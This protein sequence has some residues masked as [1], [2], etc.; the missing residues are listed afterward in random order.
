MKREDAVLGQ[1]TKGGSKPGYLDD[2]SV[3]DKKSKTETFASTVLYIDTPRW[4]G[5][6]IILKSGKGG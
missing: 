4:E 1:Y 5:V 3:E 6:P 2:E